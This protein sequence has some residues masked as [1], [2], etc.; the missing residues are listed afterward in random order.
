M[1]LR[2]LKLRLFNEDPRC[3]HCKKKTVLTNISHGTL[4]ANAATI[5]HLI[6][7]LNPRR[8]VKKRKSQRRKV[9]SCNA[10]N[11]NRSKKENL[12]LSRA[13]M[14]KRS[15]GYSLSPKGKPKI[16][17]P[18]AT[19]KELVIKLGIPATEVKA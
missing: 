2:D 7:R 1:S 5:D 4:P 6:S 12:Y 13:E 16:I 11:Q 14:I 18:V 3:Y 19:T 17:K 10:C 9:L 15:N 8:W